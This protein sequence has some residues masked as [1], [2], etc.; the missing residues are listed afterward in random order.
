MRNP[1]TVLQIREGELEEHG[2]VMARRQQE[3]IVLIIHGV[4][5]GRCRST[6]AGAQGAAAS[7]T[8]TRAESIVLELGAAAP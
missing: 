1:S 6:H 3:A 5:P 4:H 2:V 8:A 7:V